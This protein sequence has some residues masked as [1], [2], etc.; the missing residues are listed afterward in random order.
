MIKDKGS[1]V[2]T[3]VLPSL[4]LLPLSKDSN[5]ST[6][7]FWAAMCNSD[8]GTITSSLRSTLEASTLS[9]CSFIGDATSDSLFKFIIFAF[10]DGV[11]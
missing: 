7:P 9:T 5:F 10:V 11:A 1:A 3:D 2:S 6:L 4:S 8:K